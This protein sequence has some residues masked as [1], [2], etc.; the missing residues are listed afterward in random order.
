MRRKQR[1]KTDAQ[2][3]EFRREH[4]AGI[5]RIEMIMLA[6]LAFFLGISILQKS[7]DVDR[8]D[9]SKKKADGK[10]SEL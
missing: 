3:R 10:S 6:L 9:H 5:A 8:I 4:S 1:I 7:H 2:D